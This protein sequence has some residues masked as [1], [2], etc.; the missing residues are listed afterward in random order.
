MV[1]LFGLPMMKLGGLVLRTLTKPL[2]K[3]IKTHS[4]NHPALNEVCHELGQRQ[5]RALVKIDARF[6]RVY[7]YTI[8]ELPRDEAVASG[9]DLLGELLIFAVAV[10]VASSEYARSSAKAK[11]LKLA[12][13]RV[14]TCSL[15][16]GRRSH[17]PPPSSETR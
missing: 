12:S 15:V 8:T 13:E 2:A 3:A 10:A 14:R 17:H 11:E 6:R 1:S 16:G 4:K 5:N 7:D 9:A